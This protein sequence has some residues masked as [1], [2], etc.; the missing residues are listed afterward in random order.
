[1]VFDGYKYLLNVTVFTSLGSKSSFHHVNQDWLLNWVSDGL[2]LGCFWGLQ[3]T[4]EKHLPEH[5][6]WKMFGTETRYKINSNHV[7]RWI[8]CS[9]ASLQVP[10][11]V[12]ISRLKVVNDYS[13]CCDLRSC[14]EAWLLAM[15]FDTSI[16]IAWVALLICAIRAFFDPLK[17]VLYRN[18]ST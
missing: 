10:L 4:F 5:L 14:V 11:V 17:S 1:M 16:W 15:S 13:T 12:L 2:P 3:Q 9:Q 8:I 7:K 18:I 6:C